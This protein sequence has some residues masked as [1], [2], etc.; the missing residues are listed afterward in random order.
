MATLG[1]LYNPPTVKPRQDAAHRGFGARSAR[2]ADTE[3][4]ELAMQRRAL[5]AD[6]FCRARDV[7]GKAADLG[8]QVVALE[9]FPRLTERQAHD[10]LAIVAGRHGRDHRAHV[11]RQ[12]IGRYDDLR[13]A[14]RQDHDA[15]DIVAKLPDVS[16]PDMRLQYRHRI[17]ADLAF[18]QAGRDRDLVHE[19][20]D[21]F[22]NVLP[23]LRQWRHADRH[24]GKPM[25]EIFAESPLGN[26]LFQISCRG[27]DDANVDVDLGGPP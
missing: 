12:H 18:W 23:A 24:H 19:I 27:G 8:D 26:L 16:G 1:V 13:T 5:H 20:V 4:L 17:L 15:L 7:A 22:G 25:I 21:Q 3:G 6:E 2:S 11:L 10:V 14:A 9:H